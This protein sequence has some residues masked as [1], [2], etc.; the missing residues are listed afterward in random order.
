MMEVAATQ[1]FSGSS[2]LRIVLAC[3]SSKLK[4]LE[5]GELAHL[6]KELSGKP[7]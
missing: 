3:F 2:L 7:D 1:E 4:F 5:T 6:V